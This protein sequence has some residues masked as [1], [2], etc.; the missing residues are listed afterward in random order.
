MGINLTNAP[1]S[2]GGH[3]VRWILVLHDFLIYI[4]VSFCF[5]YFYKGVEQSILNFYFAGITYI[6]VLTC[7]MAFK[8]YKQVWRYGGIESYANLLFADGISFACVFIIEAI[9]DYLF[10][11]PRQRFIVY[12]AICATNLLL[13][14]S[15]RLLYRYVYRCCT[16]NNP[17]GKFFTCILKV[18]SLG[19]VAP[20]EKKDIKKIPVAILGASDTGITLADELLSSN[21]LPYTPRCFIEVDKAKMGRFIHGL[22]T[23][24]SKEANEALLE[25]LGI[26]EI[27]FAV[28]KMPQEKRKTLFSQYSKMGYK[29][30][31]Y[32]FPSFSEGSSGK[33]TMRGFNAEDLLFRKPIVINDEQTNTYY[34]DKVILITGGGGSIGSELSRQVAKASPKQLVL[35]DI[36]E[37]GV[38]DIQQELK[39]Q[40]GNDFNTA[41]EIVSVTDRDGLQRVFEEYHPEIVIHAAAHKHVPLMEKNCIEAVRNNVFGTNNVVEL[42]EEYGVK[43]FIMVSTDKAVNPTNVM[44]A[45]KRM[46]EMIVMSH[47][48]KGPTVFSATRFGNV[49]GSA[50]SV[51]PLFKKQIQAGGP[52]TVTDKRIIRY[53]MTIPEASQLVLQSGAMAK[54]G[55]LFVLDMGQPV[56]IYDL[57]ETMIRLSGLTPGT[58][59]EIIETGLRPGEKLYEELLIQS[60]NL[61]LTDNKRIFVEKDEALSATELQ[62]KLDILKDTL[63]CKDDFQAKLALQ[64]VVP[65]F[66]ISK[67]AE[68]MDIFAKN[69]QNS[70]KSVKDVPF[71]HDAFKGLRILIVDDVSLNCE[72]ATDSLN[73]VG[74]E[75]ET[76]SDG[77]EAIEIVKTRGIS[78]FDAILMDIVMPGINGLD[79]VQKIR[80]LE[81]PKNPPVQII[82]MSSFRSSEDTEKL[83][84]CGFNAYIQKPFNL[85]DLLETIARIKQ[86]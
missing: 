15:M 22:P 13:A 28:P 34:H 48:K 4:A 39:I 62:D 29:P 37:N 70:S 21:K 19:T 1:R 18:F 41:I 42:S 67:E 59:I 25:K 12:T 72:I 20:P 84:A 6:G 9:V 66:T 16:G 43:H 56:K 30:K 83:H 33:R 79:A 8:V 78:F 50:G 44:G 32:D 51:I 53:F 55:E 31:I 74:F 47:A 26:K 69:Y 46:C 61:I 81:N 73:E 49:L 77:L 11:I 75:V 60:E 57:A 2:F 38:Y 24:S 17:S 58:D 40:Y 45:T 54:S 52:I 27:I 35:L 10:S 36:Y 82:A 3:S 64:S 14:L 76:A 68:K 85:K 7:R 71:P 86:G 80:N 63:E 5:L 65:T 23:Y